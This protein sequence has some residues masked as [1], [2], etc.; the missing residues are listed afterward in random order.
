MLVPLFMGIYS[1]AR[2]PVIRKIDALPF[3]AVNNVVLN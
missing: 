1:G 2:H 3:V